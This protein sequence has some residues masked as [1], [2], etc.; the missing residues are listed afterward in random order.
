MSTIQAEAPAVT[1]TTC[2]Q[3]SINQWGHAYREEGLQSIV[4]QWEL[5]LS[6]SNCL[7]LK[8]LLSSN[9]T[10]WG[11]TK[12]CNW[13]WVDVNI[14]SFSNSKSAFRD[15]QECHFVRHI[16]KEN[17]LIQPIKKSLS[18]LISLYSSHLGAS[19]TQKE[20]PVCKRLEN[21]PEQREGER[22]NPVCLLIM[23]SK[24]VSSQPYSSTLG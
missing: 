1:K 24:A 6:I 15:T 12:G 13:G 9:F 19:P 10:K 17:S 4:K 20:A 2:S 23:P 22:E 8:R 11:K 14:H 5:K 3:S 7:R 21:L 16:D 18:L